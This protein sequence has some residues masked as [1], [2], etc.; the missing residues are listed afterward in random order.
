MS[1]CPMDKWYSIKIINNS[2][3]D[4]LVLPG[5]AKYGANEYPD[6]CLPNQKPSLLFVGKNDYNFLDA[7]FEWEEIINDLPADTLTIFYFMADSI[8][9][10]SWDKIRTKY[11][12]IKRDDLSISDLKLKNWTLTFD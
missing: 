3:K 1:R 2:S 9:I 8:N 4:I 5:Y 6:T 12:I 10:L 7:S 11:I